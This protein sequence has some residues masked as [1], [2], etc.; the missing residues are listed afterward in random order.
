MKYRMRNNFVL[1]R[2]VDTGKVGSVLTPQKSAEGKTYYI[3]E[4]GDKVQGLA[5]GD[6]IFMLAAPGSAMFVPGSTELFFTQEENV[7]LI[8]EK[9]VH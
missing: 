1:I 3:E 2:V 8:Y 4:F 7:V 9:E 6:Q 5:K